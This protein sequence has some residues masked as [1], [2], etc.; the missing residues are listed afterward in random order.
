MLLNGTL[1]FVFIAGQ[2]NAY[3]F[4]LVLNSAGNGN[5]LTAFYRRFEG[6]ARAATIVPYTVDEATDPFRRNT[7]GP[8]PHGGVKLGVVQGEF[9]SRD[10]IL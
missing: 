10:S 6:Q 8:R 9:H 4:L 1:R 5:A 7:T 3:I 2:R